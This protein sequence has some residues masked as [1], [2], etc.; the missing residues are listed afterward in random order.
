MREALSGAGMAVVALIGLLIASRSNHDV[1][2]TIG[3]MMFVVG[4]GAIFVLVHRLTGN[5]T[6]QH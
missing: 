5:K 4:V 3:V 2:S 6:Q 1:V